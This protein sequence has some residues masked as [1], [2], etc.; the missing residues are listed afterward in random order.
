MQLTM[1][2]KGQKRTL[3]DGAVPHVH[4]KDVDSGPLQFQTS[5]EADKRY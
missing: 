2:A 1:S 3:L 4:K 5:V